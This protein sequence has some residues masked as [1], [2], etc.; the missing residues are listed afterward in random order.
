MPKSHQFHLWEDSCQ[1]TP[2]NNIDQY[3]PWNLPS[4]AADSWRWAPSWLKLSSINSTGADVAHKWQGFTLL[5]A[6]GHYP[7]FQRNNQMSTSLQP[8]FRK[9]CKSW[10]LWE[11]H[12]ITSYFWCFFLFFCQIK[13]MKTSS[14]ATAPAGT[15]SPFAWLKGNEEI[16]S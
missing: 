4:E 11:W 13:H 3:I 8:G 2:I 14:T 6:P 12:V 15:H 1:T 5:Y 10:N 7:F 9:L 16:T